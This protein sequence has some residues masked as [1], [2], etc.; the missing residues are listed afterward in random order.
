[1]LDLHPFLYS[2]RRTGLHCIFIHPARAAADTAIQAAISYYYSKYLRFRKGYSAKKHENRRIST[3]FSRQ[4]REGKCDFEPWL[5]V[6]ET[7][8]TAMG[9]NNLLH[10]HKPQPM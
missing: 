10:Q 7:Y 1:M 3:I 8:R 4:S 6:F 2:P 9:A 5:C